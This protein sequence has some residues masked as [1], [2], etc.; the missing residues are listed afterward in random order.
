MASLP[1]LL[2]PPVARIHTAA[3]VYRASGQPE[4]AAGL[5]QAV[6]LLTHEPIE[7]GRKKKRAGAAAPTP[8]PARGDDPLTRPERSSCLTYKSRSSRQRYRPVPYEK[9]KRMGV[10]AHEPRSGDKWQA[11]RRINVEVRSGRRSHPNAMPCTDCGQVWRKGLKRHEYDHHLGYSAE[12]HY[13]V[14]AVCTTCH[15]ARERKRV[16]ERV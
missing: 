3:A 13:A 7:S 4:R 8:R 10:P 5:E 6:D 15:A 2:E 1:D 12:H 11:R 14:Q 16:H 9:R